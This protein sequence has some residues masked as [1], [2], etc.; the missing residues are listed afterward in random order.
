MHEVIDVAVPAQ[1]NWASAD[2][3]VAIVPGAAHS[4]YGH[5]VRPTLRSE[6]RMR[7]RARESYRGSGQRAQQFMVAEV[8]HSPSLI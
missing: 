3:E 6:V 4:Y 8:A 1:V 7:R 2:A 5:E